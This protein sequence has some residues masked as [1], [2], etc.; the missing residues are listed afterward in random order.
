MRRHISLATL[1]AVGMTVAPAGQAPAPIIDM[2]LHAH[3]PET[4]LEHRLGAPVECALPTVLPP[5]DVGRVSVDL[6]TEYFG[7]R[8]DGCA[9]LL[10]PARTERELI[11]RT[12]AILDRR[13]I[14]AV[15][16]SAFENV[17][18]WR[19]AAPRRIVPAVDIVNPKDIDLAL[20]RRRVLAK[21]VQVLGEIG[22]QYVGLSPAIVQEPGE[23]EWGF[24]DYTV[25]DPDGYRL[26]FGH[27]LPKPAPGR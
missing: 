26:T 10:Q 4:F 21:E 15:T 19:A 11:E 23:R 27:R 20:L 12:L 24:R 18:K 13:N 17:A 16:S 25:V 22:A 3:P 7:R 1:L 5:M 9:K 14:T 6:A 8:L 2:H